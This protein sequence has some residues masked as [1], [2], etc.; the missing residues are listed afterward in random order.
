MRA[1]NLTLKFLLEL[2]MVAAFALWGATVGSGAES[3]L[4]AIVAPAAAVVAWGIFAAPRSTL[5]LRRAARVPFE[6]T[7][8]GLAAAALAAAGEPVAALI[9]AVCVLLN[10]LLLTVLDQWEG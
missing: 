5:R 3:V 9:F 10:A 8:F 4:T 1:A 7:I 2:A 6:L